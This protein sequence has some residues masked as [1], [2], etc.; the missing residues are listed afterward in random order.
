MTGYLPPVTPPIPAGLCGNR[1]C[2]FT[3]G[4]L[5]S[6]SWTSSS[7]RVPDVLPARR[8]S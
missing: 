4:H 7:V 5:G 2:V 6:H 3:A 8:K 1:G